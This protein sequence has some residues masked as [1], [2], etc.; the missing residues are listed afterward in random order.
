MAHRNIKDI[1]L[2]YTTVCFELK[3]FSIQSIFKDKHYS[4][5]N[6]VCLYLCPLSTVVTVDKRTARIYDAVSSR[7]ETNTETER[8]QSL[9]AIQLE[10]GNQITF[11][12]LQSCQ[13]RSMLSRHKVLL[14]IFF[15][16]MFW[17]KTHVFREA[18]SAL[19]ICKKRDLS[20]CT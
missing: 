8:K 20:V 6:N 5:K 2:R 9:A 19:R 17:L 3:C 14:H 13:N 11:R 10:Y 12:E 18:H 16:P 1:S 4:S 7:D 15:R